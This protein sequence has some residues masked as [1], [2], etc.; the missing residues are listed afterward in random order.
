MRTASLL[1][2]GATI[3]AAALYAQ[4][5]DDFTGFQQQEQE[6]L[7]Q[8]AQSSEQE[9]QAFIKADSLAF[10]SFQR[11]VEAKWGDFVGSTR[12]DWVEYGEGLSSRSSVDFAAGTARV[13]VL[14]EA[15]GASSTDELRAAVAEVVAD[16]GT[17]SDYAV[18]LPT[19]QLDEPQQLSP[20]P[21]LAGQVVTADG[22][23]VTAGNA[24]AFAAEVV[25]QAQVETQT[26]AGADGVARVKAVVSFALVPDH[27]RIRAQQYQKL[28]EE[29]ALRFDL[30]PALVFAVIHTESY[31]N[32]KA[33]SHVPAYGLMQLVPTSGGREAYRYV[34]R[35]DEVLPPSYFYVPRQNIELG[36]GYL[37]Y[38]RKRPFGKLKDDQKALLCIV[39]AYN[40]GAGNVNR[41]MTGKTSIAAAIPVLQR[42][43]ADRLYGHLVENLP[44]EETRH[45]LKKVV[46][47][48]AMYGE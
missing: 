23:P 48:M 31:F 26:I 5:D 36:C 7:Q 44:Y 38:L 19:G 9:F 40:T 34:H 20:Q 18:E 35:K 29:H 47:R 24:D 37:D 13:E 46:E 42:M 8:F 43:P 39:A 12:K 1:A 14:V 10:D 22:A 21:V 4:N 41:A 2:V 15:D 3:A 17:S 25:D 27:V 16:H 28:V 11:E 6:A 30:Q 33:R 45:Y 32:P